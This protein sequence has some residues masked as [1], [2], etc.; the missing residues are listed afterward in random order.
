ME[1]LIGFVLTSLFSWLYT[2]LYKI[3]RTSVAMN[4]F[5]LCLS[6][7]VSRLPCGHG[8]VLRTKGWSSTVHAVRVRL[9]LLEM[10]W[11]AAWDRVYPAPFFLPAL[12]VELIALSQKNSDLMVSRS[13]ALSSVGSTIIELV[14]SAL[15]IG[16]GTISP[17]RRHSGLQR[18]ILRWLH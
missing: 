9:R 8:D 17:S 15:R 5:M 13:K 12:G 6:L 14:V 2:G 1:V 7:Q 4:I 11:H 3:G 10:P 16:V 18:R